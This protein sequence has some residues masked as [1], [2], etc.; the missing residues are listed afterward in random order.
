MP[1][2]HRQTLHARETLEMYDFFT[3]THNSLTNPKEDK[4]ASVHQNW[5][6]CDL[7]IINE[8]QG[9]FIT[10]SGYIGPPAPSE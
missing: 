10:Q 2:L 1:F 5:A 4:H 9:S 6:L 8:N 3:K 7:D